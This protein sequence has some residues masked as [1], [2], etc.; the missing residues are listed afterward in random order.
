MAQFVTINQTA[1]GVALNITKTGT[2]GSAITILQNNTDNTGNVVSIT[3]SGSGADISGSAGNWTVGKDG[4]ALFKGLMRF[5]PVTINVSYTTTVLDAPTS[6]YLILNNTSTYSAGAIKT[7]GTTSEGT[8]VIIRAG[9][10]H[11][12]E[13]NFNSASSGGNLY[14]YSTASSGMSNLKVPGSTIMFLSIGTTGWVQLGIAKNG[15]TL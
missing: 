14:V 15:L 1:T 2:A 4:S 12:N 8:I 7:I 10:N 11:E 6:S 3:N 5:Y 13:T 9:T